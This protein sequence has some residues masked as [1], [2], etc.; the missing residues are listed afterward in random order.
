MWVLFRRGLTI[1]YRHAISLLDFQ[2]WLNAI[3]P[4]NFCFFNRVGNNPPTQ[5]PNRDRHWDIFSEG[6]DNSRA[7]IIF[8]RTL[9]ICWSWNEVQMKG[10][11]IERFRNIGGGP[12]WTI[13]RGRP[14]QYRV[15]LFAFP[16]IYNY[17]TRALSF[18]G[19]LHLFLWSI[20]LRLVLRRRD[21]TCR[22]RLFL[23]FG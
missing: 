19:Y 3:L 13:R 7:D 15:C 5:Y 16:W 9:K 22:F 1:S 10:C 4:L 20:L 14:R 2:A 18:L 6:N 17:N 23:W 21:T 8:L 11:R 12:H